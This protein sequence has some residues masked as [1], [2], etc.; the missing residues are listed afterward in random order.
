MIGKEVRGGKNVMTK[1]MVSEA[2]NRG[3][4]NRELITRRG[5]KMRIITGN[6]ESINKTRLTR[7]GR[8]PTSHLPPWPPGDYS[9]RLVISLGF[10][11]IISSSWGFII[12]SRRGFTSSAG[13]KEG[14]VC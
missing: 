12:S 6:D 7:G 1:S 14:H 2:L 8:N 11:G 4:N 3:D 10:H 9:Y 5:K 13:G